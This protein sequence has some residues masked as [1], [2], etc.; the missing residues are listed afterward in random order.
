MNNSTMSTS[1]LFLTLASACSFGGSPTPPPEPAEESQNLPVVDPHNYQGMS[2][3]MTESQTEQ[4]TESSLAPGTDVVT[5]TSSVP[6][7]AGSVNETLTGEG[8][9]T[10]HLPSSVETV[11]LPPEESEDC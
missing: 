6:V 9:S 8:S 7:D 5:P 2:H 4:S 11:Q 3:P 1:I 10:T